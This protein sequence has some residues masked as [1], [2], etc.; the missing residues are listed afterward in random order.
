MERNSELRIGNSIGDYQYVEPTLSDL[1]EP[2][3][4]LINDG[5]SC[6]NVPMPGLPEIDPGNFPYNVDKVLWSHEGEHD[7]EEWLMIA[8]N[9]EGNYIFF[10]AACDYTGF[11]CQGFMKIYVCEKYK[12][13]IKYALD[14][15]D[16]RSYISETRKMNKLEIKELSNTKPLNFVY[17]SDTSKSKDK[18][19]QIQRLFLSDYMEHIPERNFG[20]TPKII[21]KYSIDFNKYKE[22]GRDFMNYFIDNR[23]YVYKLKIKDE[24]IRK[25]KGD[26]SSFDFKDEYDGCENDIEGFLINY[27]KGFEMKLK[28][29]IERVSDSSY[30]YKIKKFE[31]HFKV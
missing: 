5:Y 15:E 18:K 17:D 24:E 6:D 3:E 19:D 29:K 25:I 2:I 4:I 10:K 31:T 8:L 26:C 30:T 28:Y 27:K 11:D 22:Y 7:G 9:K 23:P 1:D 16:Y 13:L 20:K 21:L 14:E 12:D